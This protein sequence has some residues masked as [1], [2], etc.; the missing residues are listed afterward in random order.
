MK[1]FVSTYLTI[2][3]FI[4]IVP[5]SAS[6]HGAPPVSKILDI[7]QAGATS[8]DFKEITVPYIQPLKTNESGGIDFDYYG[9]LLGYPK[10]IVLSTVP[11]ETMISVEISTLKLL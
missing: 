1:K 10:T 9:N 4:S 2:I 7:T 5:L 11:N 6:H 8:I 3:L